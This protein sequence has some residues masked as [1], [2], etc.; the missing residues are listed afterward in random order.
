MPAGNRPSAA[1][2]AGL[3]SGAG[4]RGL[5]GALARGRASDESW[6]PRDVL[7]WLLFILLA[8]SISRLNGHF[9]FLI[10]FRPLLVISAGA[11]A[12]A[13][14]SPRLL[15]HLPWWR[16]WPARACFGLG[17]TAC[18][19][20]VFGISLGGAARFILEDYSK[21]L[22]A[23]FLL[24]ATMASARD[25]HMYIW[26]YVIACGVLVVDAWL[27][28]QMRQASFDTSFQRLSGFNSTYD[29]NDVGVVLL[30]GLALALY[31]FQMSRLLGKV[32]SL[33]T[34]LGIGAVLAKTG[35]RGGFLG[36]V[37]LGL[38]ALLLLDTVTLPKRLGF[39]VATGAALLFAS[40][41]GYWSQM[42]TIFSPTQ[43]YNWTA[44]TGRRM[45]TQRGLEYLASYP[46]FG[47]G[48]SNFPMAEGTLAERARSWL[49]GEPGIAWTAPHDSFLQVAS[50]MGLVG[51][52]LWCSLVFGTIW[53]LSRLGRRL[54]SGWRTGRFEQRVV[55]H[56]TRC[57]PVATV[58]FAVSASFVSFAYLEVVYTLAA[59]A[60]G[61]R[62][63]IRGAGLQVE[64]SGSQGRLSTSRWRGRA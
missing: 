50:E 6:V 27:G 1:V 44:E 36:L 56:A 54:P 46:V 41:E 53:S 23:A 40:P 30:T 57:I 8:M 11:L 43:D 9:P 58:G 5:R 64:S 4:P 37:A 51:L 20:A 55:G 3:V 10:P 42:R 33:A 22:L 48:I 49:P 29:A 47:L 18:L 28:G 21:V 34:I 32:V 60:V 24:M 35:S 17:V 31:T 25:L 61:V 39:I 26:A 16:T 52:A 45:V 15:S 13:V 62:V 38:A 19:S 14:I 12:L 63:L 7:R 2:H 59:F